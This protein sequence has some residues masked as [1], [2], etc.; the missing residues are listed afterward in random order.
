MRK[1]N[2]PIRIGSGLPRKNSRTPCV[3]IV[4][5]A[6]KIKSTREQQITN[7]LQPITAENPEAIM[8]GIVGAIA[9]RNIVPILT[10][11]FGG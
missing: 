1:P 10:E 2:C 7:P 4:K 9:N 3:A 5:S 6:V 11:G 8:C